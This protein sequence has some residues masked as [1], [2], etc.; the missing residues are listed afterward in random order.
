MGRWRRIERRAL[1]DHERDLLASLRALGAAGTPVLGLEV[2]TGPAG[3]IVRLVLPQHR[4]TLAGVAGAAARDARQVVAARGPGQTLVLAG[5]GRYGPWWWLNATCGPQQ[6][7]LLGS[8]AQLVTDYGRPDQ[9]GGPAGWG[10]WPSE[11]VGP[12]ET[13][14]PNPAVWPYERVEPGAPIEKRTLEAP[15]RI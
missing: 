3:T 6:F 14:W 4:L 12:N 1:A 7:T 9:A 5:S 11:T 2:A 8:H 10:T 13:M 15:L